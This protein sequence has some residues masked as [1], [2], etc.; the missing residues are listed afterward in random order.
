MFVIVVLKEELGKLYFKLITNS[1]RTL[2][3]Y[4]SKNPTTTKYYTIPTPNPPLS[5]ILL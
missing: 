1:N 5:L 3:S 2:T 4:L